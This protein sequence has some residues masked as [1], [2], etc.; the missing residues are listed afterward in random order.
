M[1]KLVEDG[2]VRFIGVSNFSVA[3]FKEAQATTKNNIVSNQVLYS[4]A[5]R[6]I[7]QDILP[8]CQD[9]KVTVIAYTPLAGGVG[10]LRKSLGSGVLEKVAKES[11]KTEA[12]VAL[13]WCISKE[14]VVAI[15]KSD[16]L[17]RIDENCGASGWRLSPEQKG[18]L[19]Q[20]FGG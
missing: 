16:G 7:E 4:L 14:S 8:F 11:G 6:S 19:E 18:R 9:N 2:K 17:A 20:V 1:D 3:Q 12:Q 13:N 15:P 10:N 5:D